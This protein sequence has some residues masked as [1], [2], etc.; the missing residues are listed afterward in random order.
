[1]TI[2]TLKVSKGSVI[3]LNQMLNI[4]IGTALEVVNESN[5]YTVFI[6]ES[7]TQPPANKENKRSLTKR[8]RPNSSATITSGSSE[9]WVYA[10]HGNITVSVQ[11][12]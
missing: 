12:L 3:S 10:P 4:N 1:M 5:L 7:E 9:I 8:F 11:E 2:K 6:Q